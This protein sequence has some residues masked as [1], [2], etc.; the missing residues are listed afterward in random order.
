[1][2]LT[3]IIFFWFGGYTF[4]RS[5]SSPVLSGC[6]GHTV[7][8]RESLDP[9]MERDRRRRDGARAK[10]R[11]NAKRTASVLPCFI[12]SR[13]QDGEIIWAGCT[14]SMPGLAA[15]FDDHFFFL[16]LRRF[17]VQTYFLYWIFTFIILAFAA[18]LCSGWE[19]VKWHWH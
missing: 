7:L 13:A 16:L 12:S 17:F 18:L 6:I 14:Q 15:E 9:L 3:M 19:N 1:M 10:F 8:A 4:A 2:T 5:M 11:W